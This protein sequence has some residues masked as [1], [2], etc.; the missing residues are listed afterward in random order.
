MSTI[1]LYR[2]CLESFLNKKGIWDT[3]KHPFANLLYFC[4]NK[5]WEREMCGRFQPGSQNSTI[6]IDLKF[7]TWYSSLKFLEEK[8]KIFRSQKSV[9][10][11]FNLTVEILF[12][13]I[14]TQINY[15]TRS[16]SKLF[17]KMLLNSHQT[18]LNV[19]ISQGMWRFNLFLQQSQLFVINLSF[20]V[21][22]KHFSSFHRQAIH[23]FQLKADT[24]SISE[25]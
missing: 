7:R 8:Q 11:S 23:I 10:L 12:V 4:S 9:L 15:F 5:I 13:C 2:C 16:A 21:S 22:K 25:K 1:R 19:S 6:R 3:L 24:V 20:H 18:L 14:W 17:H